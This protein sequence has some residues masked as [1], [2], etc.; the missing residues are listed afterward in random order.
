MPLHRDN[1]RKTA[2]VYIVALCSINMGGSANGKVNGSFKKA[3]RY[4]S[5]N[6]NIF[7]KFS[8]WDFRRSYNLLSEATCVEREGCRVEYILKRQTQRKRVEGRKISGFPR[9]RDEKGGLLETSMHTD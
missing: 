1:R 3:T 9:K 8:A 6:V 2:G 5:N 7:I 4:N